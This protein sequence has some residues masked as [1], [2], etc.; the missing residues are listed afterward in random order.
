MRRFLIATVLAASLSVN[1][2]QADD[3]EDLQTILRELEE[4]RKERTE[5][6]KTLLQRI[7][8]AQKEVARQQQL[9]S[10]YKA[11]LLAAEAERDAVKKT[12]LALERRVA[13]LEQ[14][15]EIKPVNAIEENRPER[16]VRGKIVGIADAGLFILSVGDDAGLKRG[17]MLEVYRLGDKPVYVGTM[18]VL[19]TYAKQ[20]VGQFKPHGK[21]RPEIGDDVGS[22]VFPR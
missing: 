10:E 17:N 6:T 15:G 20:A 1:A 2:A 14:R 9:A 11:K 12:C 19:R 13:E 4:I 21:E 18:M 22:R 8:D 3:R 7:E 5:T 16:D